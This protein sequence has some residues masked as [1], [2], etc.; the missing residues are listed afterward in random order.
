MLLR[1]PPEINELKDATSAL[2]DELVESKFSKKQEIQKAV[3]K[4]SD[5]IKQLKNCQHSH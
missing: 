2:R 3:F 5:E 4:F 1:N